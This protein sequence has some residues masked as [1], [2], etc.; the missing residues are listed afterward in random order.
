LSF[1]TMIIIFINF[2][3]KFQCVISKFIL[4]KISTYQN[5][6]FH[7]YYSKLHLNPH[8]HLL[9]CGPC[10]VWFL[11]NFRWGFWFERLY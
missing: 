11:T 6:G 2:A 5:L 3:F 10:F 9:V 1:N 4:E 7:F 8:V